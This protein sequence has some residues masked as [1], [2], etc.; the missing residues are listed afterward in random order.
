M[1]AVVVVAAVRTTFIF[2]IL[3]NLF[4]SAYAAGDI[5]VFSEI[6]SGIKIEK[7]F[8]K[9]IDSDFFTTFFTEAQTP[10]S[11]FSFAGGVSSVIALDSFSGWQ[12]EFVY[13]KLWEPVNIASSVGYQDNRSDKLDEFK[14]DVQLFRQRESF[15]NFLEYGFL[16]RMNYFSPK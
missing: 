1:V 13:E 10:S 15:N 4:S 6:S 16:G 14:V 11:R 9:E 2:I 7:Q 8:E 3:L 12:M 5:F